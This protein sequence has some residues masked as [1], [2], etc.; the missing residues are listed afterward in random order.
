MVQFSPDM[1]LVG[2]ALIH[3]CLY[4]DRGDD[5]IMRGWDSKFPFLWHLRNHGSFQLRAG[6]LLHCVRV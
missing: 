4:H 5:G 6:L 2:I 3:C 1:S